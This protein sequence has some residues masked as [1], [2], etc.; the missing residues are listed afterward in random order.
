MPKANPRTARLN[1]REPVNGEPVSG[2][3]L[4]AGSLNLF[5]FCHVSQPQTAS[6]PRSPR[7]SD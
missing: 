7:S 2:E 4:A 5:R 6:P 3:A 1:L